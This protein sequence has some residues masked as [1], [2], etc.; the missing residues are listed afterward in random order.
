MR[1]FSPKKIRERRKELGITQ[2][3][4]AKRVNSI[5]EHIADIERG[6]NTPKADMLGRIAY[7][8]KVR[9][10]YFFENKKN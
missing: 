8:L 7:A 9:E 1:I 5:R 2:A 4:L 3:V 10:S 6:C